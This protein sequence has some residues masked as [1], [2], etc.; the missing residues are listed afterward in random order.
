MARQTTPSTPPACD[1]LIFTA[2]PSEEKALRKVAGELRLQYVKANS[3][4]LGDY[5]DLGTIGRNRVLVVET[6]MGPFASQGSAAKALQW[7]A[8]TQATA[9][10]GLGMAFGVHPGR[11][12][13][14]DVLVATSLFPYDYKIIKCDLSD[15]PP[16]IAVD[17]SEVTTYSAHPALHELFERAERVPDWHGRVHFGPFLSGA[18]RIHC[19]TYRDDLCAAFSDRGSVVG[20]DM[21]GIGLLASSNETESRWIMVKGISDFAD[22]DRDS[23]IK[24]TRPTACS[25]AALFVLAALLDEETLRAQP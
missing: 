9:I 8:A 2:V 16:R 1:L 12:K 20:G 19:S 24:E 15:I 10:I 6:Q 5:V 11:Q 23:V 21:E 14:G 3:V 7:L 13:Y 4:L 18:S 17:Y 25:N 22:A